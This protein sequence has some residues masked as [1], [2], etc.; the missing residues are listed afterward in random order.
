MN[1][2]DYS[3]STPENVDLHLEL[4]G[5]GNRVLACLIDTGISYGVMASIGILAWLACMAVSSLIASSQLSNIAYGIIVLVS[6]FAIFVIMFGYF[7]LFE[8]LWQGQTPGKKIAHIRV[9]DASGEPVNWPSVI[10]RNLF[11]VIDQ[12]VFLI[13]LIVMLADKNERRLG[14]FAA[15]TLVIRERFADLSLIEIPVSLL[16]KEAGMTLDVGRVSPE[17]YELLVNF[18]KR[19]QTMTKT[20]R[21]EVAIKLEKHFRDKLSEPAADNNNAANAEFF[22]ERVYSAYQSRAQ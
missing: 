8:G 9:I 5:M 15:N 21:P 16:A 14:D 20:T 12:G 6:I 17:E 18:L 22:L 1:N 10:I 13:G 19:R 2:P 3:I 7:I 11:R 4:A